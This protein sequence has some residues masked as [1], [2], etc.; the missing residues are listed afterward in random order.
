MK[1]SS[2]DDGFVRGG[3]M[4]TPGEFDD[5]DA[6]NANNAGNADG[7]DEAQDQPAAKKQRSGRNAGNDAKHS[8]L[9]G[10]INDL[11]GQH[12][13]FSDYEGHPRAL[14][15]I[16]N[17]AFG[18]GRIT[19]GSIAAAAARCPLVERPGNLHGADIK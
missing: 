16:C 14:C 10:E 4:V 7:T 8:K 6:N 13:V 17:G 9:L 2:D 11:M 1:D 18:L 3:A 5:D 15:P 12:Y 19:G